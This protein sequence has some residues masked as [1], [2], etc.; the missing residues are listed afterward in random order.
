MEGSIKEILISLGADLC[1]IANIDRFYGAPKGFHP[2]DIYKEC[3]SVIV[4][5]LCLPKGTAFVDPKFIYG[6]F[7]DLN[8]EKLDYICSSACKEIEKLGAIAVPIPSDSPYEYWDSDKMEG[9]GLLS[10]KHAAALAGL[11]Q[12]GKN[13]LLINKKH[14]NMLTL[15]ALLTNLDLKSDPLSQELCSRNC[16]L[17]LDNC[18]QKALDG[19]TVN[20]KLCREYAYGVSKRGFSTVNCNKCRVI[21]P[22]ALGMN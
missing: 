21:C 3:K 2:T 9:R 15:G 18:P 8:A 1:G 19:S 11:G 20:Q 6:R 16:R 14:G 13:T 4:F 5:G 22:K 10:L 12:L 17:C 7:N